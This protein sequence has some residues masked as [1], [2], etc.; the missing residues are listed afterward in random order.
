[1]IHSLLKSLMREIR[2]R[3]RRIKTNKETVVID[4]EEGGDKLALMVMGSDDEKNHF[5]FKDIVESE[6]KSGKSKKKW[7][8][9]KKEL[10]IP[11]EDSFAQMTDFL[12]SSPDWTS[13]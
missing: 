5:N 10:E 7:K 12:L 2:K 11:A 13:D 3:A 9:K 6:T 1:M 4:N 8:K